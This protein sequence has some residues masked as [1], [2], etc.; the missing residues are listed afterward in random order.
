M[1]YWRVKVKPLP[2]SS[3]KEVLRKAQQFLRSIHTN[4]KRSLF[5]R[6]KYF[7]KRKIFFDNFWQHLRAKKN[8]KDKIRRLKLLPAALELLK[9]SKEKPNYKSNNK[10][11]EKLYRFFGELENGNLFVVQIKEDTKRKKLFLMSCF[12]WK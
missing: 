6:S 8:F 2:G 10:K 1:Q 3:Y 11:S 9:E 12:P 5:V 4:P 7:G